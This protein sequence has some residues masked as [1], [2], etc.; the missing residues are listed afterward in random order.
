MLCSGDS[1]VAHT[2]RGLP[3]SHAHIPAVCRIP[4][5]TSCVPVDA[6]GLIQATLAGW[7]PAACLSQHADGLQQPDITQTCT[8][9]THLLIPWGTPTSGQS[10]PTPLLV[11]TRSYAAQLQRALSSHVAVSVTSSECLQGHSPD[12]VGAQL[13]FMPAH[14]NIV[15]VCL[16]RPQAAWPCCRPPWEPPPPPLLL[17]LPHGPGATCQLPFHRLLCMSTWGTSHSKS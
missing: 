7:Q 15:A 16:Q 1:P 17:P 11:Y 8:D 14:Q 2:R 3:T 5:H 12:H 9:P 10:Q 4:A 13:P 6:Y